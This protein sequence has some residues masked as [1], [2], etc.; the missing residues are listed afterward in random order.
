MLASGWDSG[1][2]GCRGRLCAQRA[3]CATVP[4]ASQAWPRGHFLWPWQDKAPGPSSSASQLT[5][6]ATPTPQALEA[7]VSNLN[8][9]SLW[10][11]VYTISTRPDQS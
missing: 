7:E 4:S 9:N 8:A 2:T 6:V 5:V 3:F 1:Q 10:S 11:L